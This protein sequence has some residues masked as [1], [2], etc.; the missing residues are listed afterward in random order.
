MTPASVEPRPWSPHRR[1]GM[2]LLVLLIQLGLIFWLGSR[3]PIR[4]RPVAQNPTLRFAGGA[5]GELLALT[6]PTL[7]ALPRERKFAMPSQSRPSHSGPVP[8]EWPA[9]TNG[10]LTSLDHAGTAF[11]WLVETNNF[12]PLQLPAWSHS[13]PTLPDLPP[14][15]VSA[16][17]SVL[18]LEGGL[19]GRRLLAP[20]ELKSWSHPEILGSSVVEAVVDGA[21]RPVSVRLLAGSGLPSADQHALELANAARFEPADPSKARAGA[22]PTAQLSWGRMIFRWHTIP[23]QPAGISAAGP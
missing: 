16:G 13:P 5:A 3:T 20:L 9:P 19:A 22:G 2:V 21:G 6:D 10:L 11:G 23:V 4:P 1:W 18:Q 15:A 14:P 12:A 7:F 17:H 8:F